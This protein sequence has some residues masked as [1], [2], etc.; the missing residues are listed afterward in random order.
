MNSRTIALTIVAFFIGVLAA[1][2]IGVSVI[3]ETSAVDDATSSPPSDAGSLGEY[4]ID[5]DETLIAS[6]A[7]VPLSVETAGTSFAIE[8]DLVS[9]APAAGAPSI[10][11]RTPVGLKMVQQDVLPF[12]FPEFWVLRTPTG[13]IEGGPDDPGDRTARF[14]LPAGLSV[15]DVLS[16]EIVDPLMAFPM[17]VRF[18]LSDGAPEAEPVEG[19][20]LEVVSVLVDRNLTF[21]R[22]SVDLDDPAILLLD[23]EGVGSRWLPAVWDPDGLGTVDLI[24]VGDDP[25][26]VMSFRAHGVQWIEIPGSYPVSI[27]QLP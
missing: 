14:E 26:E 2:S 4:F 24:W 12:V 27:G 23:I 5:P 3:R 9:L 21:I 13:T 22:V 11:L 15:D 18:E 20:R 10:T 19:L 8:Y 17:D 7:L 6:T 25:P 1:S 16:I